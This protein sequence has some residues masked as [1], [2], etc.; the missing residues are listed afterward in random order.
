MGGGGRYFLAAIGRFTPDGALDPHFGRNGIVNL[1]AIGIPI[2]PITLQPDGKL[3]G[4]ASGGIVR[5]LLN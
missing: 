4:G 5:L 2:A 3:V 1:G